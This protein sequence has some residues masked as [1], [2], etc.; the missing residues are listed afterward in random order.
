MAEEEGV[1]GCEKVRLC[2]VYVYYVMFK[3]YN[4]NTTTGPLQ[5][6]Q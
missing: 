4:V 2:F 3:L 6:V 5:N 1:G